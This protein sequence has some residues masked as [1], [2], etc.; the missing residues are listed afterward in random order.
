[1]DRIAGPFPESEAIHQERAT[2]WRHVAYAFW[3]DPKAC[4]QFVETVGR[5]AALFPKS[6]AIQQE[7]ATARRNLDLSKS[8][9]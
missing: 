7:L 8:D 1:M 5:I 3:D 2:A 6:A 4:Q 9:C